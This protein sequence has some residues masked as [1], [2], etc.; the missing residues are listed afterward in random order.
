MQLTLKAFFL[1]EMMSWETNK[2][3]NTRSQFVEKSSFPHLLATGFN[4]DESG[5]T[6]VWL[7]TALALWPTRRVF[8]SL[9]FFLRLVCSFENR[10]NAL[11]SSLPYSI[12]YSLTKLLSE[13][14]WY[15]LPGSLC[16]VIRLKTSNC[17]QLETSRPLFV[18]I[19]HETNVTII[20]IADSSR[21]GHQPPSPPPRDIAS[22]YWG[23][24]TVDRSPLSGTTCHD[25]R[26]VQAPA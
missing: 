24:C 13:P 4:W 6:L 21:S 26:L 20:I 18:S 9:L 10:D 22:L 14:S 8:S 11:L 19:L 17:L 15:L 1:T 3:A 5:R 12:L 16:R 25:F 23:I 7:L 2:L